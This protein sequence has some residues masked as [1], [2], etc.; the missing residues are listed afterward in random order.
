[1]KRSLQ[2]QLHQL[3][4]QTRDSHHSQPAMKLLSV[5]TAFV[6]FQVAAVLVSTMHLAQTLATHQPCSAGSPNHA[7]LT[8]RLP[9]LGTTG[10]SLRSQPGSS[11]AAVGRKWLGTASCVS[12]CGQRGELVWP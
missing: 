4:L 11:A 9:P 6:A 3:G 10:P 1:M 5:I 8:G 2:T 7:D 12:F